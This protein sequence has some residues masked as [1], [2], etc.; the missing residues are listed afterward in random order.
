MAGAEATL[1]RKVCRDA[2]RFLGVLNSKLG[3]DGMPD[4][5]F[6]VPAPLVL[7]EFKAPGEQPTKRQWYWIEFLRRLGYDAQW[8]DDAERALR[9]LAAAVEARAVHDQAGE[10]AAGTRQRRTVR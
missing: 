3:Q 6:W 7:I 1:E 2:E 5:I 4:R 9:H 8:F 10:V